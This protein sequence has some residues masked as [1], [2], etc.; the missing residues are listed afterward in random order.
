MNQNDSTSSS[1][2]KF[3]FLIDKDVLTCQLNSID[4]LF[5]K[6][7]ELMNRN[8]ELDNERK[9]IENNSLIENREIQ[10]KINM[11]N[12]KKAEAQQNFY[13]NIRSEIA[14]S[15]EENDFDRARKL[16]EILSINS[17][18]SNIRKEAD[19]TSLNQFGMNVSSLE[20]INESLVKTEKTQQN[21]TFDKNQDELKKECENVNKKEQFFLSSI[22]ELDFD[23]GHVR[24]L[25]VSTLF[26]NRNVKIL[27]KGGKCSKN[28]CFVQEKNQHVHLIVVSKYA[29]NMCLKT[30]KRFKYY[31]SFAIK[32]EQNFKKLIKNYNMEI[33]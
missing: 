14:R 28:N 23:T 5:I 6:S 3:S 9:A 27:Y 24:H 17:N 1:K 4:P 26:K 8:L 25:I 15:I 29:I 30:S 7:F 22:D 10:K 19:I 2:Q 11:L 13:E 16:T 21:E 31:K 12:L 20:E 32:S 18:L 33:C